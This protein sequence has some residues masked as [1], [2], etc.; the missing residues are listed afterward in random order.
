MR[1]EYA[2]ITIFSILV[3]FALIG[4]ATVLAGAL[5]LIKYLMDLPL[6]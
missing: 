2:I 6:S 3:P 5:I 4:F 1:H